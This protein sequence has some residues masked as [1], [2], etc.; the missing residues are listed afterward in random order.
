MGYISVTNIKMANPVSKLSDP[1]RL[2]V[3]FESLQ[4]LKCIITWKAI[5]VG[6]PDNSEYD[7]VIDTVDM[8][9][10]EKGMCEF[11]WEL[12]PPDY[13]KLPSEFDIFDTSVLMILVYVA[14]Q[15]F[16]RCSY[17]TTHVYTNEKYAEEPPET[18]KW[19]E[20]ERRINAAKPIIAASEIDWKDIDRVITS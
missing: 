3:N 10:T 2:T 16:F 8:E 15:E 5:Y 11:D 1:I 19:D 20:V 6:N 14:G 12:D 4:Q 7:Q 18:V 9:G 17:L 13:T